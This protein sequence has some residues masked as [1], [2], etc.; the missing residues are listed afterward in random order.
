M[1]NTKRKPVADQEEQSLDIEDE[2]LSAHYGLV[3]TTVEGL[4]EQLRIM[5][6]T[7]SLDDALLKL[8]MLRNAAKTISAGRKAVWHLPAYEE[9]ILGHY[10]SEL[11]AYWRSLRPDDDD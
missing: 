11:G 2:Q 8:S 5:G 3:D 9:W 6:K 7:E 10:D 1:S 4:L